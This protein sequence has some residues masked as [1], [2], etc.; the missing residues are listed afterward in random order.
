MKMVGKIGIQNDWS[1]IVDFTDDGFPYARLG[2]EKIYLPKKV[3]KKMFPVKGTI[4][5]G[6]KNY[7]VKHGNN[8]VY[9]FFIRSIGEFQN[10]EINGNI[11]N[12]VIYDYNNGAWS[13]IARAVEVSDGDIEV[14][15]TK[16]GK[17]IKVVFHTDGTADVEEV[18]K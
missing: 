8:L 12:Q 13:D 17:L 4:T 7:I 1:A 14:L 2:N 18:N 15:I 3:D 6:T 10:V 16:D 5:K 9:I 11:V